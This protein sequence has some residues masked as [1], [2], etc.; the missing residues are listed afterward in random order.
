LL[1]VVLGVKTIFSLGYAQP[2][3]DFRFGLNEE[4]FG[5][6]GA[7]GAFCLVH[8]MNKT[9]YYLWHDLRE[10]SLRDAVYRCIA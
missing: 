2:F 9:G 4:V 7:G 3:P 8:A 6:P 5:T 1:D 10:N